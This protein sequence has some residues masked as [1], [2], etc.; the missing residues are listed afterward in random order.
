MSKGIISVASDRLFDFWYGDCNDVTQ[1]IKPN[2]YALQKCIEKKKVP[3]INCDSI[4][5]NTGK[6]TNG[7]IFTKCMEERKLGLYKFIGNN[8]Y[9]YTYKHGINKDPIKFNPSGSCVPG[10]LYFA[11]T[12]RILDFSNYGTKICKVQPLPNS[13]V[14]IDDGKYK[15]DVIHV[16]LEN[17]MSEKDFID[18][19]DKDQLLDLLENNYPNQQIFDNLN[20]KIVD[21]E[22]CKKICE[23]HRWKFF[24]LN[25]ELI[26]KLKMYVKKMD[27]EQIIKYVRNNSSFIN[28]V[29]DDII[30]EQFCTELLKYSGPFP[31]AVPK[32]KI[33]SFSR[34]FFDKFL[35]VYPQEIENVP[36]EHIDKQLFDWYLVNYPRHCVHS[37]FKKY[38]TQEI[39]LTA[40]N[41]GAYVSE[42]PDEYIN[43]EF[44]KCV[45]CSGVSLYYVP[46]KYFNSE[47]FDWCLDKYPHLIFYFRFEKYLTYESCER[48]IRAGVNISFVPEKYKTDELNKLYEQ[49]QWEKRII[50]YKNNPYRK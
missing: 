35:S 27:T 45:I 31:F 13:S 40:I 14:Y 38:L 9:G 50:S 11:D 33:K 37:R 3:P 30:N 46:S 28:I 15:A 6:T 49:L 44:I 2:K 20:I 12:K 7:Y 8:H 39:C 1:S 32:G 19:L 29:G 48:A 34:K 26:E 4:I 41:S 5:G 17:C 47:L 10:G 21:D 25:R 36:D 24:T 23:L 18:T 43:E 22:I 16:D 42:I